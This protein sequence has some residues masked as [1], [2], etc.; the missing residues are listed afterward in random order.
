MG[1]GLEQHTD[2][3]GGGRG[4]RVPRGTRVKTCEGAAALQAERGPERGRWRRNKG[5][6]R[7]SCT[8]LPALCAHWPSLISEACPP[9]QPASQEPYCAV[10]VFS[11]ARGALPAARGS[12][13]LFSLVRGLSLQ[14]MGQ[15]SCSLSRRGS[16]CST[17]VSGPVL[18]RAGALPA[19]HGSVV[20]FSLVWGL[21]LQHVGQWSCPLS[22]G[23]L[24]A[25]HGSVSTL[26]LE[27]QPPSLLMFS[28]RLQ[29]PL[30]P[31]FL[32]PIWPLLLPFLPTSKRWWAPEV[33]P[34][35]ASLYFW[36]HEPFVSLPTYTF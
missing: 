19:A 13:V 36:C 16:P 28:F 5:L 20:L 17:W 1:K 3:D 29:G 6:A 15:W 9:L 30:S 12:V 23:A 24:P 26:S 33:G 27:Y 10:V 31:G 18:S 8:H 35:T 22:R 7:H 11:L 2:H 32:L 34:Q 21:S 14:H 4:G 25:A